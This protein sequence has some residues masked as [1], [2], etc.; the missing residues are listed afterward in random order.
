VIAR[1]TDGAREFKVDLSDPLD[2]S[3]PLVAGE[4]RLSAWC[5]PPIT[6]TPVQ[7]E[8]FVGSVK[9]G[10]AVNFR[11]I[12]FNPHGHGT[13]TECVGHISKEDLSVN[14]TLKQFHMLCQVISIK[15]AEIDG[16]LV[17]TEDQIP[18]D[19][20]HKALCIRTMPNAKD[21]TTRPYSD[22]NPPFIATEAMKSIVSQGIEHLL[23]DTPSVDREEDEGILASHH[24]FWNYPAEIDRTKTIT[25]L[26]YIPSNIEDGE[27]LMEL[28]FAPFENDA[29]PSRPVLY[30][31][32]D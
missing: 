22:T 4:N 26:I 10:G 5:V 23:I 11:D 28:Q 27:Y 31:L 12:A 15:P 25:E 3:I 30:R 32:L 6:M 9:D 29:S 7:A 19:L 16:D 20:S 8:G 14:Q 1:I 24:L 18:N 2:I 21:K 17:I 13:H